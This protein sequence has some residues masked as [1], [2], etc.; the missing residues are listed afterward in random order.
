MLNGPERSVSNAVLPLSHACP[1][2]PASLVL[3]RMLHLQEFCFCQNVLLWGFKTGL[4]STVLLNWPALFR[5]RNGNGPQ[6]GS[7][8]QWSACFRAFPSGKDGE[9]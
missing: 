5:L 4:Q 8:L 6:R 9:M 7:E 2:Y 1:A 3:W